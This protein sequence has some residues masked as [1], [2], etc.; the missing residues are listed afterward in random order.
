MLR[1]PSR[2][3]PTIVNT[4]PNANQR[5][6]R[7]MLRPP[8]RHASTIVNTLPNA[9]QRANRTM[10]RPAC[11]AILIAG[12]GQLAL[13]HDNLPANRPAAGPANTGVLGALAAGTPQ[14]HFVHA[15]LPWLH[16]ILLGSLL[17]LPT[18]LLACRRGRHHDG[19]ALRWRGCLGQRLVK[20]G[21]PAGRLRVVF[22]LFHAVHSRP[23]QLFSCV[24]H[25][26]HSVRFN[27]AGRVF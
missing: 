8:S 21:L 20:T 23:Q 22:I 18:V 16:G 9:N 10:L 26:F 19:P 1:P 12:A 13:P 15:T 11:N 25:R 5:A 14:L 4:L 17:R 3:A 7:T 6:N 2:H 24:L 27:S